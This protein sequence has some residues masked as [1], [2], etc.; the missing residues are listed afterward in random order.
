MIQFLES[1]TSLSLWLIH[2]FIVFKYVGEFAE[3]EKSLI[4]KHPLDKFF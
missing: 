1:I 2:S 3:S 4:E